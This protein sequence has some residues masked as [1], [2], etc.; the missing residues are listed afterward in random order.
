MAF[1]L[2]AVATMSSLV[3][4]RQHHDQKGDRLRSQQADR[5]SGLEVGDCI[6]HVIYPK[7]SEGEQISSAFLTDAQTVVCSSRGAQL[8]VIS[9]A[10]AGLECSDP[11]GRVPG[12]LLYRFAEP[13][14]GTIYCLDFLSG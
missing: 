13:T 6:G 7:D 5:L 11:S 14:T 2:V 8:K 3:S 12:S 9:T 10:S 1:V 4:C